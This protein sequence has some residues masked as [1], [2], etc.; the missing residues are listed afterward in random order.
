MALW[1]DKLE[2]I[3][4]GDPRRSG[5]MEGHIERFF[6]YQKNVTSY[7]IVDRQNWVVNIEGSIEIDSADLFYRT[8]GMWP[9][10]IRRRELPF[11][12]GKVS[13]S[14]IIKCYGRDDMSSLLNPTK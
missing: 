4:N 1:K 13:G 2:R 12:I 6:K 8:I 9:Y 14:I 3:K 11:N 5:D 7:E 10:K